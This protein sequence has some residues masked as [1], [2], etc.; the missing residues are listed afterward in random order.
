MCGS[1]VAPSPVGHLFVCKGIHMLYVSGADANTIRICVPHV[2]NSADY[3]AGRVVA[4]IN[5][6]NR[7]VRFVKAVILDNGSIAVNYDHKFSPEDEAANIVPHIV[8]T[9]TFAS[10][11][12]IDKLNRA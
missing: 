2:L 7:E 3:D 9:L 5:E 10:H 8:N 1:A 4:A 6:T 11:Y 12:I